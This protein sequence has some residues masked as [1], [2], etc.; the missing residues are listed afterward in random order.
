MKYNFFLITTVILYSFALYC[1]KN[2]EK[3][4]C[5]RY[6]FCKKCIKGYKVE[7]SKCKNIESDDR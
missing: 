1:D 3:G 5:N 6:G 4:Y 2:C 7:N